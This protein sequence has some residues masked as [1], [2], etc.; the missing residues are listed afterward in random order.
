MAEVPKLSDEQMDQ[1]LAFFRDL[2]EDHGWE[3]AVAKILVF[4]PDPE[5]VRQI[6][7]RA[8]ERSS[9]ADRINDMFEGR[10]WLEVADALAVL[11]EKAEAKRRASDDGAPL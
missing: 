4:T 11:A 10:R 6:E 3:E 8:Y 7:H 9:A 1:V 2:E 5:R